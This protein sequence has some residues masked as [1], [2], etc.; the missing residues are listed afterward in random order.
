[1]KVV[2]P[3]PS[4]TPYRPAASGTGSTRRHDSGTCRRTCGTIRAPRASPTAAVTAI[5]A[6]T[7]AAPVPPEPSASPSF[8]SPP[9]VST[10]PASAPSVNVKQA[11][12]VVRSR[13]A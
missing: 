2:K 9:N 5:A 6:A 8:A 13:P 12:S 1:M 11:T 7:T 3:R 4:S 10:P